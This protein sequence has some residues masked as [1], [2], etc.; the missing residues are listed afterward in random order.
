MSNGDTVKLL[1]E[2]NAGTKM[3]VY[4]MDE[5]CDKISDADFKNVIMASKKNTSVLEMRSMH[6]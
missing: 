3:A 5:I 6:S 2:C 1:R 4:S